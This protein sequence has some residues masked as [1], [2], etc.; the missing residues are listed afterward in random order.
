MVVPSHVV[1]VESVYPPLSNSTNHPEPHYKVYKR[2][3]FGLGQLV[4]LNIVVSWDVR[5]NIPFISIY[6]QPYLQKC[7]CN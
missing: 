6:A 7:H 3:F 5:E 1:T 2:R 4:L